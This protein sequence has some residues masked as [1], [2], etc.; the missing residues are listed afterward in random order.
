MDPTTIY[1]L[2]NYVEVESSHIKGVGYKGDWLV[3]V[4]KNN[5]AYRYRNCIGEF[6]SLVAANSVGKYFREN[7]KDHPYEKLDKSGWPE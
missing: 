7:V 5:S 2:E 6:Q 4:F 1:D 3:V